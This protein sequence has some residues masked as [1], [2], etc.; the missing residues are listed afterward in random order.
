MLFTPMMP[1]MAEHS[2]YRKFCNA[3]EK[4]LVNK[5]EQMTNKQAK[6]ENC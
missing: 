3:R 4:Q 5:T 2:K 1:A 6:T